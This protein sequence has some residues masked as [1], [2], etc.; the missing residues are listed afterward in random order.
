MAKIGVQVLCTA[1]MLGTMYYLG[2]ECRQDEFWPLLGLYGACFG[3]YALVIKTV[4]SNRAIACFISLGIVLR[5]I[6]LFSIP[7]L[8]DDV[9]RYLWDGKLWLNGINPFVHPP[10]YY[11]QQGVLPEGLSLELYQKLN[12]PD[13]HTIYPPLAQGLFTLS[14]ALFPHWEYGSM[15]VIKLGILLAE[16]GS[17]AL[18]RS[19]L[20][21][22][23]LAPQQILLYTLNPLIIMELVGNV[24]LEALMIFFLLLALYFFQK[25]QQRWAS[26]ALAASIASKLLPLMF[27]PFLLRRWGWPQASMRHLTLMAGVLLLL[28]LPM[29]SWE[30]VQGFAS[31]LDLYFQRFEFNASLYYLLRWVFYML[32]GY[33]LIIALGPLLGLLVVYFIVKMAR[34]EQDLSWEKLPFL[35]LVAFSLYLFTATIIHPWYLAVPIALCGLTRWRFPV[36]WSGLVVLSYSHYDGGGFAEN[37]C[38]I[39]V[40]YGVLGAFLGMEQRDLVQKQCK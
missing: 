37:Y 20:R 9:Y 35:M 32:T 25:Q 27:L 19:L 10:S 16:L 26:V 12:S 4:E 17:I 11:V 21:Q 7:N 31:S 29:L 18:L 1:V 2:Y 33:N 40:E 3:A 30:F 24:H 22:Y 8:S 6:L 38:L 34:R 15:V 5:V 36:L 28:F 23:Q 14:C 13:Y 39:G